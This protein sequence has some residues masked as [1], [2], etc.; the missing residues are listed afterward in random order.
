MLVEIMLEKLDISRKE[1]SDYA[2][3]MKKDKTGLGMRWKVLVE[4]GS[5]GLKRVR[6][7]IGC[8]KLVDLHLIPLLS[9]LYRF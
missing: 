1:W 7:K 9:E 3:L 8:Q 4:E 5:V 6:N 2:K